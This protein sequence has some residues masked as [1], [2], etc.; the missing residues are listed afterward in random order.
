MSPSAR[1][2]QSPLG[3]AARAA[4]DEH[5]VAPYCGEISLGNDSQ[6]LKQQRLRRARNGGVSALRLTVRIAQIIS[7][8]LLPATLRAAPAQTLHCRH[9]MI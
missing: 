1:R 5:P 7:A 3:K 8:I 6:L 9:P 4:G 2:R